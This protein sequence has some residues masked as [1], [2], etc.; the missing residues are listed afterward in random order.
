[1]PVEPWSDS[2]LKAVT[3][4]GA[5]MLNVDMGEVEKQIIES[6]FDSIGVLQELCKGA[7]LAAGITETVSEKN[8]IDQIAFNKAV[9]KKLEDYSGRHIRSLESFSTPF[10]VKN[11]DGEVVALF[12]PYYFVKMLLTLE[13]DNI[14]KGIKR[15]RLHERINE[16]HHRKEG[17]RSSDI[18]YFLHNIITHQLRNKIKPPLLDYDRS[19]KTLKIIDSTFYFF[20]RHAD[21]QGILDDIDNPFE[22]YNDK[23]QGVLFEK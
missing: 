16:L 9:N 8:S 11:K 17:V 4:K 23:P 6:S 3:E 5:A 15:D 22:S 13:F 20:L 2:A 1:M 7:C 21:K 10:K 18:S 12:I 19:I 14:V